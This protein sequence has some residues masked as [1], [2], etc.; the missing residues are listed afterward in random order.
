MATIAD[1]DA[2]QPDVEQMRRIPLSRIVV[3]E[4]FNPRGD[5]ADDRELEH[6]ADSMREHGCIIPIRV[7]ATH[8]GDY[9]VIAGARRYRAAG[10]AALI[11]I[12]AIIRP[13]GS[14]GEIEQSDLLV[15]AVIEND[16]RLD[17]DPL[18]RARAYRRLVDGGLTIKGVAQKLSITQARVREHLRLLTLPGPIQAKLATGEVP[19]RA[20]RPLEALARIHPELATGAVAEVLN[21]DQD[22]HD[23]WTWNDVEQDPLA[24]AFH[25]DELPSGVYDAN[26]GYGVEKFRLTERAEKNLAALEKLTGGPVT[27]IRFGPEELEQARALGALHGQ[28]W[29]Q[30]IVGDDVA[31]QLAGDYIA[32]CLK[33]QRATRRRERDIGRAADGE[34]SGFETA[35]VAA[36]P[37]DQDAEQKARREAR[38]AELKARDEAAAFNLELGSAIYN[39]LSR[40]K[41]DQRTLKLLSTTNVTGELAGL[42]MRGA[43]YGFPGWLDETKQANGNTK[44]VY[45]AS[46][47][48]AERRAADYLAGAR[49]AGEIAGRQLALL[50]MAVYA[51]EDAVAMSNRSFH[52]LTSSGPWAG[53]SG[54]LLDELARDQ[55]PERT[56]TI[57]EPTLKARQADRDRREVELRER[58]E[59]R[60][61]LEGLEQRIADL[62]AE[63]LEHVARD[64]D[65]AWI[66]WDPQQ[67]ELRR[68]VDHARAELDTSAEG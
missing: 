31:S 4:G 18:A 47:T 66:G 61:R 60:A 19:M 35:A 58:D 23:A 38:Q 10:L 28:E 12:P 26:R 8:H 59:A 30:V 55:L 62:N 37:S 16:Q 14:E 24:V 57:L 41:L 1:R 36:E 13:V 52:H 65:T 67:S 63:Q 51:N 20:A 44:R 48:D 11:E 27:A 29:R 42:A 17:L 5:A 49:N 46:R 25:T 32:R 2:P 64:V 40:V 50:A 68:L 43:R 56:I 15:E 9:V 7:R 22:L 53:E 6:L 33:I 54:E 3:P 39:S 21:P 45:V 34:R